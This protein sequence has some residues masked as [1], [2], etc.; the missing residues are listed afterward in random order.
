MTRT[1][2]IIT[3]TYPHLPKKILNLLSEQP[4]MEM[5]LTNLYQIFDTEADKTEG[6]IFQSQRDLAAIRIFHGIFTQRDTLPAN[7]PEHFV[8]Q[9]LGVQDERTGQITSE[10][11]E[12]I[13]RGKDW[14]DAQRVKENNKC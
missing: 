12:T 1:L 5:R 8:L 11:P 2:S 13:A 3:A 4:H 6:P 14:A 7:Y 9:R 10:K